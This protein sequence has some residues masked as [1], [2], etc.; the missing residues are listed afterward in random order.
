MY[1]ANDYH[2]VGVPPVRPQTV[3]EV[4]GFPHPV[5]FPRSDIGKGILYTTGG[6]SLTHLIR[7]HQQ[8]QQQPRQ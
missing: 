7:R 4:L 3:E 8:Q 1:L 2:V 6:P 5:V